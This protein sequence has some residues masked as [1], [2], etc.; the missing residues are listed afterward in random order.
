M[1]SD[2]QMANSNNSTKLTLTEAKHLGRQFMDVFCEIK[3]LVQDEP[4]YKTQTVVFSTF[5]AELFFPDRVIMDL[6][7]LIEWNEES[8]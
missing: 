4:S 6:E 1:M 8:V 2:L 7:E 3:R 5:T